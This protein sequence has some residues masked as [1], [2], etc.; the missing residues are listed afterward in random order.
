M[1]Q[2]SKPLSEGT[3]RESAARRLLSKPKRVLSGEDRKSARR[4]ERKSLALVEHD[5]ADGEGTSCSMVAREALR[6][7]DA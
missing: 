6:F 4:E 5:H 2:L 3:P 7:R 1:A